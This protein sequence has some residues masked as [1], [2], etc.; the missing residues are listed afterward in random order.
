MKV[1]ENVITIVTFMRVMA[2]FGKV[3]PELLLAEKIPK[4]GCKNSF[5]TLTGIEYFFFIFVPL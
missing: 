4:L 5:F 2:K 3:L 1:V